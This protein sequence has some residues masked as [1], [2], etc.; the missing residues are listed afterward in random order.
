MAAS[1]IIAH[2]M[3]ASPL[4]SVPFPWSIDVA[5]ITMFY[6]AI[7]YY[8][9]KFIPYL[10]N[11]IYVLVTAIILYFIFVFLDYNKIIL[12]SIDLKY[13]VYNNLVLD[14]IIPIVGVLAVCCICC[15]CYWV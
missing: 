3:S 14:F 8:G 2:I 13:K 7:G 15:I 1:F 9:K 11:K 5:F 10:I 4:G 12:H 6:Y